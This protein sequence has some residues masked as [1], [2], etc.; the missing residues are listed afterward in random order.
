MKPITTSLVLAL[1]FIGAFS[2]NSSYATSVTEQDVFNILKTET[3]K[4][5][6]KQRADL[7]SN[8][9]SIKDT[10]DSFL[11]QNI[12]LKVMDSGDVFMAGCRVH[13]CVE[14]AATIVDTKTKTL[15][16]VGLLNFNCRL[17][18]LTQDEL[19]N[20]TNGKRIAQKKECNSEAKLDI[21]IVRKM[22]R[23]MD[24]SKLVEAMQNWGK[25]FGYASENVRIIV[26]P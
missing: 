21:F 7:Y 20:S 6:D 8:N 13:S 4:V 14:K 22:S 12:D 25:N 26:R 17:S 15:K 2:P 5:F 23:L 16:A 24:E 18:I 10:I 11:E 9:V 19:K 3:V 1:I